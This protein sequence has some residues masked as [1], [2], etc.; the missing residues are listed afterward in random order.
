[1]KDIIKR[2]KDKLQKLFANHT[3]NKDL[4]SEYIKAQK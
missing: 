4:Y 3:S 2:L 1:M